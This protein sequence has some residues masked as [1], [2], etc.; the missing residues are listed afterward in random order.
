[1][2]VYSAYYNEREANEAAA[3]VGGTVQAESWYGVLYVVYVEDVPAG[4]LPPL[5]IG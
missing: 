2:T 3:E 1:M 5:P 4:G